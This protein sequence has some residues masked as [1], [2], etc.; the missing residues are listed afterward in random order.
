MG[1]F[2]FPEEIVLPWRPEDAPHHTKKASSPGLCE[3]WSE[4]ANKTLAD[5]QDEARAIRTANA[6]VRRVTVERI[7]QEL[8]DFHKSRQQ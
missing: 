2:R 6:V 1:Q 7:S 3:L 4:V 8:Q 5:T